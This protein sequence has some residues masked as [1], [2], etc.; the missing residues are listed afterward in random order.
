MSDEVK[1]SKTMK[2]SG[3]SEDWAVWKTKF[4]TR[5]RRRGHKNILIG[6][7]IVPTDERA[8]IIEAQEGAEFKKATA[9]CIALREQ[10]L[11]TYEDLMLAMTS[12]SVK[13]RVVFSIVEQCANEKFEDGDSRQAW[14]DLEDKFEAKNAPTRFILKE[15]I[16]STAQ[17]KFQDPEEFI[18]D[19][20]SKVFGHA[21]AGGKWDKDDTLEHICCAVT[22]APCT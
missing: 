4:L 5:A 13:G 9:N 10:N 3:E 1:A 20:E 12:D 2:F 8:V 15:G 17:A 11:E 7:N 22:N 14:V 19:V 16:M 6:V 18:T 21:N